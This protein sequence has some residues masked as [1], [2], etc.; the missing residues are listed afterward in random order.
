MTEI[1]TTNR[2]RRVLTAAGAVVAL[3]VV[4]FLALRD[5]SPIGHWRSGAARDAFAAHYATAMADLPA[6][7]ATLDVRTTSGVVRVYRFEGRSSRA[8]PMVLLPGTASASPVWADN[9]P[10]LLGI[11]DV[12]TV[13]L[14]GEPGMSIQDRPI[15]DHDDQAAWLHETL[16]QLPEPA[17]DVV[18]LSIGG[19][20]AANL[21]LRRPELVASLTLIEP[22]QV[23]GD[24]PVEVAVRSIPAAVHWFPKSWR[25]GFASWTAGGAP[26]EDVPVAEMIESG[27]QH[28]A[29]ALPMPS[30]ID[31][32]R[33][34]ALDRPVLA[35]LA[36]R[37]V[38]HDA[39]AAVETAERALGADRVLLYPGATHA[40][41]GEHPEDLA[42]DIGRFLDEVG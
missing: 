24:L 37:S 36:G 9:L 10:S 23:F 40:I 17:F 8:T 32:Q 16:E 1:G 31:E 35:I 21:G 25:D 11:G 38:M 29:L 14:L 27:M 15:E 2:R 41:N 34:A 26:V 7:T 12:Y 6:P 3:L 13:D 42:R 20:T 4:V 30:R 18:G 33:L 22:V 28:Y 19:W 39:R 5:T